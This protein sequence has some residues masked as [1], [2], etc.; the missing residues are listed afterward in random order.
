[1]VIAIR[2]DKE[3]VHDKYPGMYAV[4]EIFMLTNLELL[5]VYPW[6]DRHHHKQTSS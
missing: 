4:C 1:M 3:L 5:T 6:R 2:Y